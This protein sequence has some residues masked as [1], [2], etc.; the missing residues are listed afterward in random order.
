MTKQRERCETCCASSLPINLFSFPLICFG[1]PHLSPF[2]LPS[3]SSL[4]YF[5][6]SP[7]KSLCVVLCM[8]LLLCS[9]ATEIRMHRTESVQSHVSLSL[10]PSSCLQ[11]SGRPSESCVSLFSV[12]VGL[13]CSG[14]PS[15]RPACC[16]RQQ[17]SLL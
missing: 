10:S 14:R 13:Q 1:S 3:H 15:A 12:Q 16:V 5:T 9:V 8:S 6:L 7:F 4:L 17:L 2:I 11:C